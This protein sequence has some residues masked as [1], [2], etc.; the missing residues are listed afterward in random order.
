[1]A[2]QE[3]GQQDGQ[4]LPRRHDRRKQQR[5]V[6]ADGV[7]DEQLPCGG[8]RQE[9][10][11]YLQLGR[12]SPRSVDVPASQW[13]NARAQL[14]LFSI[15]DEGAGTPNV[16]AMDSANMEPSASGC[17]VTNES[18]GSSCPL[19]TRPA[20]WSRRHQSPKHCDNSTGRMQHGRIKVSHAHMRTEIGVLQPADRNV[21]P[22]HALSGNVYCSPDRLS[23]ADT[24][25]T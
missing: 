14:T 4:E 3:A 6:G 10:L 7:R 8:Q 2:E 16:A 25:V 21:G 24:M 5:A 11:C 12:V 20:R 18:A 13:I 19:V 17:R 1:V 15:R 23:S 22:E 9:L